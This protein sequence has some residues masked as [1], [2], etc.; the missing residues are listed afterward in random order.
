M[1][2]II[3]ILPFSDFFIPRYYHVL[4]KQFRGLV[5]EE[6]DGPKFCYRLELYVYSP[7]FWYLF[8]NISST[9]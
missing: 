3:I 7:Y 8:L 5:L 1:I 6:T 9:K 2:F 4:L